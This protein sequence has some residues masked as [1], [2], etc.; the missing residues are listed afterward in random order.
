MALWP[1]KVAELCIL[2]EQYYKSRKIN[3][4]PNSLLISVIEKQ[5]PLW[6]SPQLCLGPN[7]YWKERIEFVAR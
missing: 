6:R 5:Y 3:L 7:T 2:Q 4:T 1:Q